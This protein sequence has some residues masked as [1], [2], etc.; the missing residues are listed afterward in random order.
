M[1]SA[2]R[3]APGAVVELARRALL[4][5]VEKISV[6]EWRRSFLENVPDHGAIMEMWERMRLSAPQR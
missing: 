6:P 2:K 5:C 4:N 3:K 1:P